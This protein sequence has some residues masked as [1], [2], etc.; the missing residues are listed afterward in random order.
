MVARVDGSPLAAS[1][2]GFDLAYPSSDDHD[3][4]IRYKNRFS[5]CRPGVAKGTAIVNDTRKESRCVG[6]YITQFTLSI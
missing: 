3:S 1:L 5:K 4:T 6:N 2:F